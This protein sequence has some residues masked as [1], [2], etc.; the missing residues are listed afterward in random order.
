MQD[1]PGIRIST[2]EPG[3][4]LGQEV[5]SSSV[6]ALMQKM[7]VEQMR[8]KGNSSVPRMQGLSNLRAPLFFS[9]FLFPFVCVCDS[10]CIFV[11]II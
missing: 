4:P 5:H 9:F 8:P 7:Q 2:V 1:A 6:D 3:G 10:V 11:V